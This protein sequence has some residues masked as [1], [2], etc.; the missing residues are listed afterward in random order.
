MILTTHIW[1]HSP[2]E[3]SFVFKFSHRGRHTNCA[4]ATDCNHIRYV[5]H[6]CPHYFRL[7]SS[8]MDTFHFQRMK[9]LSTQALS[10]SNLLRSYFHAD[11]AA[12]VPDNLLN[13]TGL[14]GR[15]NDNV[16]GLLRPTAP[17]RRASQASCAVM[18]GDI[19]QPITARDHRS[20]TTARYSQPSSV[21]KYVMS[22]PT[23]VPGHW[24]KN[25]APTDFLTQAG[26]AV[27]D[28]AEL[29]EAFALSPRRRRLAATVSLASPE[30]AVHPS[31]VGHRNA[32]LTG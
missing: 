5:K 19:D 9:E 22:P 24:R 14:H 29:P 15:V 21:R 8:S 1:T 23:L 7:I 26:C 20:M 13:S 31:G 30:H 12:S 28:R 3:G 10:S 6:R 11:Y 16:P 18:R 32:V 17:S 2:S 4:A 25:P 27:A